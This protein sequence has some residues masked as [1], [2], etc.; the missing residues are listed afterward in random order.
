MRIQNSL[1]VLLLTVLLGSCAKE[2]FD[3]NDANNIN[4]LGGDTWA[5]GPI[6]NWINDTLTVPYNISVK[7]KWDQ[8]EDLSDITKII[9]PPK[10]EIIIPIL[11]AT[12]R[13]WINPYIAEGGEL[14]F[15]RLSP[16][17]MY[18]VGSPAFE[19]NGGIKLGQAEGGRKIILL[20]T[21]YV[22][23][24][25]MPDYTLAD[26]FWLKEM[27]HTIHHEF[28]HILHQTVLYPNEFKNLNPNLYTAEWIN[29]TD[30]DALRD[31]FITAYSM[32]VVDDDF[33]E[34]VSMMLLEGRAG[35]EAMLAN[36]PQGISPR[37]TTRDQAIAR[38]R[39]KESI[40]VNYFKQ[41]W[42]INFYNLQLR[43]RAAIESLIY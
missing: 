4:G 7:Y 16:K 23:T 5:K 1:Y 33:V 2:D 38:L 40:V 24:K 12:R 35:F 37:G 30:E 18:M 32:N 8:W 3:I 19:A 27:F 31:G 21:N 41:T 13:A 15:K 26:T 39:A 11:S 29:Y 28:A 36:I 34:M 42:N 25:M 14:F 6:D 10:E 20:A 9:V 17:F 22:K 43:T